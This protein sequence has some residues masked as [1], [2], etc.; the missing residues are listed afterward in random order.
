M[1]MTVRPITL[2]AANAF[3]AQHHRHHKPPRGCV[4]CVSVLGEAGDLCGVAIIGRPLA[5]MLQDGVTCEVTRVC[6]DGTRNACS[7]LYSVAARAA[8][9]LGYERI[10]T[11]ILPDEGGASLRAAGWTLDRDGTGGGTWSRDGRVRVD[12]HNT[13][14]K[15]RWSA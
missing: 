10:V 12:E 7:K 15:L 6:T 1:T 5:R 2:R 9:T 13:A 3:V 8:R 11:Y 14:L 4:F